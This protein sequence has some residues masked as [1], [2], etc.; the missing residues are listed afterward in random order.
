M[1]KLL[2]DSGPL[3]ALFDASDVYH[4]SAIEFIKNNRYL[5]VTTMASITE[6][7]YLLDF[8]KNAQLDFLEWVYR[9]GVEIFPIGNDDMKRIKELMNKYKDVPMDFADACLVY[10]AER[11]KVNEIVTIDKD[12]LIYRIGR[13]KKFKV[14][15][16]KA[17]K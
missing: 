9:G 3:I 11:L 17:S 6:T 8:D 14:I 1:K 7:L 12:F 4:R 10:A 15:G 5:L 2:I 13:R 16:L